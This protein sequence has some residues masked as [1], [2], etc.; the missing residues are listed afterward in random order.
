M[1]RR[2]RVALVAAI[3]ATA[4]AQSIP[5]DVCTETRLDALVTLCGPLDTDPGDASS[6]CCSEL[7]SLNDASCFCE[8][9]FLG[10]DRER[11]GALVP[12]LATAPRR[13]GVNTR[14]GIRC[15]ALV[16]VEE[17]E[18]VAGEEEEVTSPGVTEVE[19]CGTST[20]IRLVQDGCAGTLTDTC[21]ETIAQLND[22]RCFCEDDVVDVLRSFPASFRS[23]F[24]AAPV[25]CGFTARGGRACAPFP[26]ASPAQSPPA[27]F[28]PYPP[29]PPD[30]PNSPPPPGTVGS[31]D[32][33]RAEGG[34]AGGAGGIDQS[35]IDVVRVCDDPGAFAALL[36]AQRCDLIAS[37]DDDDADACCEGLGLLNSALCL[38]DP[39]YSSLIEQLRFR[40][41]PLFEAAP[42]ACGFDVFALDEEGTCAPVVVDRADVPPPP[43]P[44][45]PPRPARPSPPAP[46]SPRG[47]P[48]PPGPP[49]RTVVLA[50]SGDVDLRESDVD[51]GDGG[52]R[53]A[54]LYFVSKCP[55]WVRRCRYRD[56]EKDEKRDSVFP[57]LPALPPGLMDL[58]DFDYFDDGEE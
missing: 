41:T 48:G 3:L 19:E 8:A 11:Q 53:G 44:P 36:D 50:G 26:A 17:E 56:E 42:D 15:Q 28:P 16:E 43:R 32:L 5:D 9:P 1:R 34:D 23:M 47:P 13:C 6:E 22:A 33:T 39:S 52:R 14:V 45:R 2:A 57:T 4:R 12:A 18:E 21:C 20:L 54:P 29:Y 27:P 49:G 35:R 7:V 10:F 55:P 37:L 24:A 25:E 31:R 46:N 30:A 40:A 58:M 38:C 51:T